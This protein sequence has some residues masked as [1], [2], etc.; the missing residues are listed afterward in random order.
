MS[1]LYITHAEARAWG[2]CGSGLYQATRAFNLDTTTDDVHHPVTIEAIRRDMGVDDAMWALVEVAGNAD[3]RRRAL[4]ARTMGRFCQ[5]GI[6]RLV[7]DAQQNAPGAWFYGTDAA[8]YAMQVGRL[9]ALHGVGLCTDEAL[10]AAVAA[11]TTPDGVAW[12]PLDEAYPEEM[13]YA[14]LGD[15]GGARDG[16]ATRVLRDVLEEVEDVG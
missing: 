4:A 6:A 11:W 7:F 2:A 12:M 1:A 9:A 14:V 15:L 3:A 10:E 13:V 8:P 5:D 16:R